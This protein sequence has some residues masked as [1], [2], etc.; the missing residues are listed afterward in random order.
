M[1]T[2]DPNKLSR[3]ERYQ[4]M[5]GCIIPRPIALVTSI[6]NDGI[7]NAAPFSYFNGV[8]SSP[9]LL[10]ISVGSR[11]GNMKDTAKNIR[12]SG[13]FVVNS[14]SRAMAGKMNIAATDFPPEISEIEKAGFATIPSEC[15]KP[16]RIAEAPIQMECKVYRIIEIG[17]GVNDLILGKIL[18]LH[19]GNSVI[20]E[21]D[22][23]IDPYS[24]DLIGRLGGSRY[25]TTESVFEM[26]RPK[27]STT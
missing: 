10:S 14:V 7:V 16:P 18:R 15:I 8:S 11:R 3:R 6:G 4:L 17:E 27:F 20:I 2:I 12:Q 24:I 26:I 19:L 9:P 25:C 21:D 22:Y 13:E 23:R 5:I 1:T